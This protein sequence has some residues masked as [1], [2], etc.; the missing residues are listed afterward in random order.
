MKTD[1]FRRGVQNFE[2][3]RNKYQKIIPR[4]IGSI[5]RGSKQALTNGFETTPKF[6]P[7]GNVIIMLVPMNIGEHII[8][9]ENDLNRICRYIIENPL[10][11]GEDRYFPSRGSKF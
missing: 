5:I 10:K 8:R 2:P 7:S 4:S 6:T 3:L 11:W 9:D 1:I